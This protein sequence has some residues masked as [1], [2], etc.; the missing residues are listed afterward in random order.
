MSLQRLVHF[1][2]S[3]SNGSNELKS[4]QQPSLRLRPQPLSIGKLVRDETEVHV[5]LLLVGVLLSLA[6]RHV[7]KSIVE[8][9]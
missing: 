1:H 7:G 3:L 2:L 4:S 5:S 9:Q 6:C 8:L